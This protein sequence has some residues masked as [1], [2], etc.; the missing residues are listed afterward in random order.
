MPKDQENK[1]RERFYELTTSL[2][3][4]MKS[5]IANWWLTKMK[6]QI[7]IAVRERMN[8]LFNTKDIS[9]E[10]VNEFYDS[11]W[12]CDT[13]S[14][15]TFEEAFIEELGLFLP[16]HMPVYDWNLP[17]S[18]MIVLII[19]NLLLGQKL[20]TDKVLSTSQKQDEQ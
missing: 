19:R 14:K 2:S 20:I 4:E 10:W 3:D 8:E 7:E 17:Y 16:R 18:E 5:A 6:E 9:K 1:I 12:D 15:T 13:L 11:K